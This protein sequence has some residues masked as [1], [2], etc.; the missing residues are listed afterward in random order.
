MKT[1]TADELAD[2]LEREEPLRLVDVLKAEHYERVHLPD[3]ENIPVADLRERAPS[4]LGRDET[5]VVYC[6]DSK[7]QA[8]PKA[9]A[10]LDELG[11]TDV[12]DF[13]GGIA[14]WRRSGRPLVRG[15]A[16]RAA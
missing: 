15:G 12:H 10:M 14:E 5:I 9:A 16:G 4:A 2:R 6:S 7:C 8:S 1:I 3:A 13:E 11:Y